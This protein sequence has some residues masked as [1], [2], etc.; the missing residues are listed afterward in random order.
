MKR[1][2]SISLRED[3]EDKSFTKRKSQK[4]LDIENRDKAVDG[5][6]QNWESYLNPRIKD[7]KCLD[8]ELIMQTW[9]LG[10]PSAK[11]VKKTI[12]QE[13]NKDGTKTAE[14]KG[15]TQERTGQ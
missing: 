1:R 11:V 10:V 6:R 15:I 8:L 9:K 7:R 5:L 13:I 14:P 4:E 12:E 2:F 3:A